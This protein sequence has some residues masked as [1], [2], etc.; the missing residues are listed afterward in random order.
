MFTV[1]KS[2]IE[3]F[4]FMGFKSVNRV[5]TLTLLRKVL[6]SLSQ[7]LLH[8]PSVPAAQMKM[9]MKVALEGV[10]HHQENEAHTLL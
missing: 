1:E 6:L 9:K 4:A 3:F 8:S 10:Q 2:W 7:S 5:S